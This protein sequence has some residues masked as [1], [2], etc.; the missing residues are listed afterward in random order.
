MSNT[1]E[2]NNTFNIDNY[3]EHSLLQDINDLRIKFHNI[4]LLY[5]TRIYDMQIQINELKSIIEN[6][7]SEMRTCYGSL[8]NSTNNY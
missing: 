5:K 4:D 2:T 6:M 8:N 7:K 3:E 1:P